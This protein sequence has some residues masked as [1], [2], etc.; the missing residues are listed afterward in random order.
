[1]SSDM[2]SW[3]K[4][5]KYNWI[6]MKPN[7]C[8]LQKIKWWPCPVEPDIYPAVLRP[9]INLGGMGSE[10]VFVNNE[11]EFWDNSCYGYFSTPF[12]KGMHTSHDYD[13]S[14]GVPFNETTF[15]GKSNPEFPGC[16]K[17]WKLIKKNAEVELFSNLKKL[18]K[19]LKDYS[20]PLNIECINGVII[21]AHL[22]RGDCGFTN[23]YEMPLYIVPIWGNLNISETDD[24][25][26]DKIKREK[27]VYEVIVDS[28]LLTKTG[29]NMQRKAIVIT[30]I[31]PDD[32]ND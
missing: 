16:F 26:V 20:G 1:M 17:Y 27:G 14:N 12:I 24:I 22:R 18:L 4:N 3:R 25:D 6:Y 19:K 21:E 2:E 30:S 31:L 8:E 28:E 11:S 10:V 29:N 32:L 5:P 9:M 13:I 15:E 23:Q 7:L